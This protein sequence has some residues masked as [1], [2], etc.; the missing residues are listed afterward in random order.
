MKFKSFLISVLFLILGVSA[1]AQRQK[2][3]DSFLAIFEWN[4]VG[5]YTYQYIRQDNGN[6]V[7][8]GPFTMVASINERNLPYGWYKANVTGKYNLKG[9]HSNG[10][11]HGALTLDAS[12]AASATNGERESRTYTFRG[13]FK[14]GYPHGNFRVEYPSYGVKVNVNYK[15]G[16][17]VGQFYVKAI[18][19]DSLPC[20]TT[21]TFTSDGRMTGAWKYETVHGTKQVT[22]SNG[23]ITNGSTY[24]SSLSAKAKAYASGTITK[25]KLLKENIFVKVDS[26]E[27]GRDVYAQILTDGIPFEKLGGYD[28]SLSRYVKFYYLER[29][30]TFST[31][32]LVKFAETIDPSVNPSEAL[33]YKP[34]M[35]LHYCTVYKDSELAQYCLGSPSW[36]YGMEHVYFTEDQYQELM[37]LIHEQKMQCVDSK[38]FE[39]LNSYNGP[40]EENLVSYFSM[41]PCEENIVVYTSGAVQY[42]YKV[43]TFEDYYICRGYG[44]DVMKVVPESRQEIVSAK[45]QYYLEELKKFYLTETTNWFNNNIVNVPASDIVQK[46]RCPVEY[47]PIISYQAD[48]IESMEDGKSYEIIS[49]VCVADIK[50]DSSMNPVLGEVRYK[51]YRL[52]VYLTQDSAGNMMIDEDKT[53]SDANFDRLKNDYDTIDALD[54][55]IAENDEKIKALSKNSFKSGFGVYTSYKKSINMSV[56]HKDLQASIDVRNNFL[57]VQNNVFVFVDE[58]KALRDKDQDVLARCADRSDVTKAYS[59][60][61][62]ARDLSWSP[63]WKSEMLEG[64]LAVQDG[65]YVFLARLD[66]IQ[67]YDD[68]IN[69]KCAARK[70][71]MKAYAAYAK[72]RDL[73][74]TSDWS[75][76]RL[77][78]YVAVQ[79]EILEFDAKLNEIQ[80]G[81][82]E[83]SSRCAD[84]KELVKAYSTYAKAR[85][86]SWTPGSGSGKLD[87]YIVVQQ[88]VL[89]FDAMLNEIFAGDE[90][91]TLMSDDKKDILKAYTA[92][93]KTRDLSWTP[94]WSPEKLYGYFAVQEQC[95]TFIDLRT[96]A[97]N[98]NT[99]IHDMKSQASNMYKAYSSYYAD[100]DQSWYPEVDFTSIS[101]LIDIQVR[102]LDSMK[103]EDLAEFDKSIKKQKITDIVEILNMLN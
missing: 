64:Y 71:L 31:E 2:A 29:I 18:G 86:L 27:L 35:G 3:T 62:K 90:Q 56:N 94:D 40:I 61:L 49:T 4:F 67:K 83:I 60:Y 8:D 69:S 30:P 65:V 88:R 101:T 7:L 19:D 55:K 12:M 84:K 54:A 26:M 22:F 51:T 50:S 21:G 39:E 5:D 103:K 28:F 9:T 20:T 23:V 44:G 80:V 75:A 33:D 81:D 79:K 34:S 42:Y 17:L 66:E 1:F 93:A 53:F 77:D 41:S 32:G 16:I 14:N 72:A 63:E 10:D 102:Y 47:L 48:S 96:T 89:E 43:E 95:M 36:D 24:D 70:D 38:P 46:L 85:N 59:S 87:E 100:C 76:A 78:E 92:Y 74:W 99:A 68:E 58:V 45:I 98:N 11:L 37:T 52:N 73:S 57:S 25:E 97:M 15:D 82:Q 91:I 6:E 13:N